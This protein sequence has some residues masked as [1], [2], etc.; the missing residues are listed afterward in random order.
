MTKELEFD[1]RTKLIIVMCISTLGII[2]KDSLPLFLILILTILIAKLFKVN[3]KRSFKKTKRLIY[4]V[5]LIAII[6]SIFSTEGRILLSAGNFIILNTTGLAKSMQF[7]LR[8][9]IIIFSV[10]IIATSNSREIV[11]GFVQWG[12]PYDIAFMVAL[13]IRFL[14]LLTEEI[15]DSLTA[16]QLR[17]IEINNI[18][19]RKRI[20][21]YSYIFT[22]ILVGTILKAEKLSIAIEMRGFRAYDNRTSYL[23]LK[24]SK[25]DYLIISISVFFTVFSIVFYNFR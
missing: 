23:V 18:P 8:M 13:G 3:L 1:P 15:K 14:P 17:G 10:T 16:I 24:M 4:V 2:I 12:L 7:I 20:S 19:I 25:I 11:Q 6:Q 21:L 22:P 5:I 9:M